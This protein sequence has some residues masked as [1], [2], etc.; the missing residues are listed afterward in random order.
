MADNEQNSGSFVFVDASTDEPDTSYGDKPAYPYVFPAWEWLLE[1]TLRRSLVLSLFDEDAALAALALR[2]GVYRMNRW[3]AYGPRSGCTA[4]PDSRFS[5][6]AT[7]GS[8]H[9]GRLAYRRDGLQPLPTGS[10][11]GQTGG[12]VVGENYDTVFG[13]DDLANAIADLLYDHEFLA[14]EWESPPEYRVEA[15]LEESTNGTRTES[16]G[17]DWT[18]SVSDTPYELPSSTFFRLIMDARVDEP[19]V[20]ASVKDSAGNLRRVKLAKTIPALRN[21]DDLRDYKGEKI[22]DKGYRGVNTDTGM[23]FQTRTDMTG[24]SGQLRAG[25]P[26]LDDNGRTLALDAV[27]VIP[28][29]IPRTDGSAVYTGSPGGRAKAWVQP[30]VDWDGEPTWW[31]ANGFPKG[32]DCVTSP[33]LRAQLEA[34]SVTQPSIP[35]CMPYIWSF[36]DDGYDCYEDAGAQSAG[37]GQWRFEHWPSN[38]LALAATPHCMHKMLD[39]L[40]KTVVKVPTMFYE[41]DTKTEETKR[42]DYE[43]TAS[44]D[45]GAPSSSSS[46]DLTETVDTVKGTGTASDILVCDGM[47]YETDAVDETWKTDTSGTRSWSTGKA[48]GGSSWSD[49]TTSHYTRSRTSTLGNPAALRSATSTATSTKRK[50]VTTKTGKGYDEPET[51]TYEYGSEPDDPSPSDD[52]LLFPEWIRKWIRKAELF[53]AYETKLYEGDPRVANYTDSYTSSSADGGDRRYSY[54]GSGSGSRTTRSAKG[55]V[56]LGE[57]DLETGRFPSIDLVSLR[58]RLDPPGGSGRSLSGRVNFKSV[59]TETSSTSGGSSEETSTVVVTEEHTPGSDCRRTSSLF[60]VVEWKFDEESPEPFGNQ[61][62][63]RSAWKDA[64]KALREAKDDLLAA[65]DARRNAENEVAKWSREL[66]EAQEAQDKAAE[67]LAQ[68]RLDDANE[69]LRE[70]ESAVR[71][72]EQAAEDAEDAVSDRKA[73][74]V[75]AM[76]GYDGRKR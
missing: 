55:A 12:L 67:D 36:P 13:I 58:A 25:S 72:K 42:N 61:L 16:G 71:E 18:T 17:W 10:V 1:R 68:S 38:L 26:Y 41:I 43:Y 27:G 75:E 31:H 23:A 5:W 15:S 63:E 29:P 47:P 65:Q 59:T 9:D 69:S 19:A 51:Q 57:L 44:S 64:E 14:P 54:T 2:T 60:V 37:I 4:F 6:T 24:I 62:P 66:A 53:M 11:D 30:D 21:P 28:G 33:K 70:A 3:P 35:P 32:L 73:E 20:S 49:V 8:C 48:S 56:S 46:W 52:D 39:A 7:G 40:T 22:L 34:L 76:R 74:Y 50:T 45:G